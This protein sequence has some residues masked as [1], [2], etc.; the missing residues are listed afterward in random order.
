ML[1]KI[2]AGAGIHQ[3]SWLFGTS[4]HALIQTF[5]LR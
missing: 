4:T 2:F 5:V 3:K 1:K